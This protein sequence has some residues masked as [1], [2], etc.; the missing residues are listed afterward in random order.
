MLD[1]LRTILVNLFTKPATRK[2]PRTKREPFESIRGCIDVDIHKCIFCGACQRKC[3]SDSIKV[4]KEQKTW[5]INNFK[6]IV[7]NACVEACPKKC[8]ISNCCYKDPAY[9]KEVLIRKKEDKVDA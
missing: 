7:C 8:V 2:Y 4:D 9:E 1:M 6:C 3:P 5:E